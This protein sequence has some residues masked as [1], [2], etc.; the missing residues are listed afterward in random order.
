MTDSAVLIRM[1]QAVTSGLALYLDPK[2]ESQCLS[3]KWCVYF[4]DYD[5]TDDL[6]LGSM[7]D[8]SSVCYHTG[9]QQVHRNGPRLVFPL[10]QPRV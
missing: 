9:S 8:P 7:L 2:M 5:T 4:I 1:R 6:W 3:L 10:R